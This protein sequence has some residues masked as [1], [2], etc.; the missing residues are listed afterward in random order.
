MRIN[1]IFII[2]QLVLTINIGQNQFYPDLSAQ[3]GPP[4]GKPRSEYYETKLD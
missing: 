4:S 2:I 3:G 1:I